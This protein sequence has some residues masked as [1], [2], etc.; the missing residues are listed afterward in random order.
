MGVAK[1]S[2]RDFLLVFQFIVFI[3]SKRNKGKNK[4][5]KD[6]HSDDLYFLERNSFKI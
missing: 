6:N 2:D 5:K 3:D 4:N 1:K